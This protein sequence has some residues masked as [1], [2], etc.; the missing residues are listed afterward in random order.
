MWGPSLKSTS[1]LLMYTP[2]IFIPIPGYAGRYV[3]NPFGV[4][5]RL[6]HERPNAKGKLIKYPERTISSSIDGRTGYPVTKLTK[7]NGRYG[8]Q[9]LH[10][11]IAIS[12]ISQPPHKTM[13]N[14]INGNKLDYSIEN[15][16]WVTASENSKHAFAKSL[17]RIPSKNHV[18]VKNRCTGETYKS[19]T[20]ASKITGIPYHEV[21]R[22]IRG[23]RSNDTCLE[24]IL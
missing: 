16:E 12:F 13:V 15:L 6:A 21:K 18:K 22:K 14:H 8:S 1:P 2:E 17:T 4:I 5:K 20:E 10:R 3:I 9:F 11:L 19:L 24:K 23:L 7:P